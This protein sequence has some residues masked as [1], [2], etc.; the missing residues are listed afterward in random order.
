MRTETNLQTGEIT[1]HG[2]APLPNFSNVELAKQAVQKAKIIRDNALNAL[3]YDFGDG[4]VIQTRPQDESNIRNAIE[5]MTAASIPSIGW[6]M[7]DDVKQDVT[8]TD[9]QEALLAGQMAALQ[10]WDNYNP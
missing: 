5:I 3:I 10:I 2:D 1:T 6:S 8:V 4:R 7:I 9:L